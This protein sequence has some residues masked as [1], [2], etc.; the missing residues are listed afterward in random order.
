[1]LTPREI[2][3]AYMLLVGRT[4]KAN[5]QETASLLRAYNHIRDIRRTRT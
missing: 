5:I 2:Q 3:I 1:M 4:V